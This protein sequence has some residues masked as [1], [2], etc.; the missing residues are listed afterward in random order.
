MK[1][2]DVS[3]VILVAS[4]L[5][6]LVWAMISST[7]IRSSGAK[8]TTGATP[9]E[10]LASHQLIM[11]LKGTGLIMNQEEYSQKIFVDPLQ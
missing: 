3:V 11:E 9:G 5:G 6:L 1:G 8:R 2:R 10:A 7:E 4:L